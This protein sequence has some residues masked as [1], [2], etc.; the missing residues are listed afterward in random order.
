MT[1]F[2]GLDVSLEETSVCV[3]DGNGAVVREAKVSTDPE[4]IAS[5]LHEKGYSASKLG[6][7]AGALSTWLFHELTARGW[8]VVCLETRQVHQVLKGASR[9]DG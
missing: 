3:L 4:A 8:D 9:Q 6:F 5:W 7:E 1:Y 2:A